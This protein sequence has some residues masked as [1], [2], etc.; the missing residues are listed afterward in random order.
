MPRPSAQAAQPP[1]VLASGLVEGLTDHNEGLDAGRNSA[2]FRSC[3][4]AGHWGQQ[5]R[6]LASQGSLEAPVQ[7]GVFAAAAVRVALG[8]QGSWAQASQAKHRL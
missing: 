7:T 1:A 3:R 8:V 5:A 6:A 4:G 2:V